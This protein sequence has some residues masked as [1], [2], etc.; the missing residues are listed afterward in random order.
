MRGRAALNDNGSRPADSGPLPLPLTARNLPLRLRKS[1]PSTRP[2]LNRAVRIVMRF[3]RECAC[4]R[5][6][7]PD[8]E[9][10][11]REALANAIIHGNSN[12]HSKRIFLRCYGNP[13]RGLLILVRDEGPGFDPE[14]VPDPRQ[15]DRL[16][17]HHGRGLL[18]MR[19]LMDRVEYRKGGREVLLYKTCSR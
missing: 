15:P 14:Q 5:K 11:V 12:Q 3:A 4:V 7:G 16:D 8:L 2:A 13:R 10:A 1:L 17:L 6:D 19:E 9:I 18:L